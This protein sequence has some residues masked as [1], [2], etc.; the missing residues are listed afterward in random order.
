M[1]LHMFFL[2]VYI[3]AFRSVFEYLINMIT[4]SV[5]VAYRF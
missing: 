1:L 2:K 4:W 5:P 3:L